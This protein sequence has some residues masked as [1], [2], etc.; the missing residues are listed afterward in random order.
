MHILKHIAQAQFVWCVNV[1]IL[2]YK[3]MIYIY[4]YKS[5]I[6]K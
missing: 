3:I 5:K 4:I 1:I 2:K 6:I